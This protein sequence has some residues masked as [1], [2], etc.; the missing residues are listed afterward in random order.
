VGV[1]DLSFNL[2]SRRRGILDYLGD[3]N[4]VEQVQLLSYIQHLLGIT[5]GTPRGGEDAHAPTTLLPTRYNYSVESTLR[6]RNISAKAFE[7]VYGRMV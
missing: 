4:G 7:Q 6:E 2:L 5:Q 3:G 1:C